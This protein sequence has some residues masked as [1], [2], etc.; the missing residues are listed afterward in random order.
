[1]AAANDLRP[2]PISLLS[3]GLYLLGDG[4]TPAG[5]CSPFSSTTFVGVGPYPAHNPGPGLNQ[6][7][8]GNYAAVLQGMVAGY[9]GERRDVHIKG[10]GSVQI[11][12]ESPAASAANRFSTGGS[13]LT[14]VAGDVLYFVYDAQDSNRWIVRRIG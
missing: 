13:D 3:A 7:W 6:T 2:Q 14:C 5:L 11:V 9:D 8:G 1:M 10:S 12:N 4:T